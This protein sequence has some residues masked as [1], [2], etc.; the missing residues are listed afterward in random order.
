MAAEKATV[1]I[2]VV[3][4]CVNICKVAN[5]VHLNLKGNLGNSFN[6]SKGLCTS[7]FRPAVA[8]FVPLIYLGVLFLFCLF[9]CRQIQMLRLAFL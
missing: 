1:F 8:Q 9:F 5:A 3:W 2:R 7:S 6:F 4:G